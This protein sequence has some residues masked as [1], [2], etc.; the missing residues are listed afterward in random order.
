MKLGKKKLQE[1]K[2][3]KKSINELKNEYFINCKDQLESDN[4]FNLLD[5]GICTF[6]EIVDKFIAIEDSFK[7]SSLYKLFDDALFWKLRFEGPRFFLF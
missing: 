5:S 7:E 3:N 2:N 6:Q 4:V 1:L